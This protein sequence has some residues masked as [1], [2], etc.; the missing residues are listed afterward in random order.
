MALGNI[1]INDYEEHKQIPIQRDVA[2]S[3]RGKTRDG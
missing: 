1:V 2:Q 3:R